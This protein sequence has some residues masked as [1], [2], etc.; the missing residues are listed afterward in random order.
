MQDFNPEQSLCQVRLASFSFRSVLL[1]PLTN[2][3]NK[4]KGL[5]DQPD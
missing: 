5:P 1:V 2:A 4:L 3:D